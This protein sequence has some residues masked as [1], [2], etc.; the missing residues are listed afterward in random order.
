MVEVCGLPPFHES[1][2]RP[3]EEW[4]PK[5]VG[6]QGW[7]TR[8]TPSWCNIR[9][10]TPGPPASEM[11]VNDLLYI[12]HTTPR[13]QRRLRARNTIARL[14]GFCK[15][16]WLVR[17]LAWDTPIEQTL[18]LPLSRRLLLSAFAGSCVPPK[19]RKSCH[20]ISPFTH[21][22]PPNGFMVVPV[23]IADPEAPPARPTVPPTPVTTPPGA[24]P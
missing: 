21:V 2:R 14:L 12:C 11:F 9:P 20:C 7:A 5:L 6:S 23:T 4:A 15:A 10:L 13:E 16:P 18:L 19:R 3:A 24:F 8:R 22:C 17:G 1:L